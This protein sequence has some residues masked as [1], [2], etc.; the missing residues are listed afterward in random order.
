MVNN[1]KDFYRK[2]LACA[3]DFYI[4]SCSPLCTRPY[5]RQPGWSWP[6]LCGKAPSRLKQQDLLFLGT[7]AFWYS[8][9]HSHKKTNIC[10]CGNSLMA[11]TNLFHRSELFVSPWSRGADQVEAG[12][13]REGQ[14]KDCRWK[15]MKKRRTNAMEMWDLII[16]F[17]NLMLS[18]IPRGR[19]GS[20]SRWSTSRPGTS[21]LL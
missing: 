18:F 15:I 1:S 9:W 20:L 19:Q 13:G 5:P 2:I 10:M 12:G 7:V 6:G 16:M 21:P 11:K 4:R 14:R 17:D 3:F 8:C